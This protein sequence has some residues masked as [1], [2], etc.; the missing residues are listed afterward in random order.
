MTIGTLPVVDVRYPLSIPGV[1][2]LGAPIGPISVIT[3]PPMTNVGLRVCVRR[4][5]PKGDGRLC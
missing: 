1:P 3:N 5:R 2:P 4:P